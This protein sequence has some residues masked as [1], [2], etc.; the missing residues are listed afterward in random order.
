MSL[1]K[2]SVFLNATF[3]EKESKYILAPGDKISVGQ[4]SLA[5]IEWGDGSLTRLGENTKI[6]IEENQVSRDYTKI[7]ISFELIAGKTWSNV[8][9]FLGEESSFTQTFQ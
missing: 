7:N 1:I 9:S 2:G 5:L 3:L 8:V 6:S 4:E